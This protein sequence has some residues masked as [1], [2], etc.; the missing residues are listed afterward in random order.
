VANITICSLFRDSANTL[1]RYLKQV[2][3]LWPLADTRWIFIEGDSIDGTFDKLDTW[4]RGP[5]GKQARVIK[6]NTRTRRHGSCVDAERFLVLSVLG[7]LALQSV[8][9]DSDYVLWLESDLIVTDD[10]TLLKRL[11]DTSQKYDNAAVAPYIYL[12]QVRHQF[13]DIWGFRIKDKCFNPFQPYAD[14]IYK[15]PFEVQSAGSCVLFPAKYILDG[16]RFNKEE[17]I[18]GLCKDVRRRGCKII[19]DP[20]LTIYHP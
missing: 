14:K 11:V 6:H 5:Y 4:S 1:G 19:A 8:F 15:E 3:S 16:A 9:A 12:N 13:Y 20:N 17:V 2:I 18:V 10:N 7:N